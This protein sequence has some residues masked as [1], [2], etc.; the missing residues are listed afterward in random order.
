M[1]STSTNK[2]D[3][4]HISLDQHLL[5]SFVHGWTGCWKWLG[6]LESRVLRE[7]I[8]AVPIDRPVYVAGLARS[9]STI[10]LEFLAA[11][12]HVA[13]HRYSDFPLIFTPWWSHELQRKSPVKNAAPIERAHGDGIAITPQSPEAMEEPLWM[14]FFQDAHNPSCNQVMDETCASAAFESFYADHLRKLL[15]IRGGRRYVSKGNY[16][17]TRLAYLQKMFPD[18]RV[19]I[20]VRHPVHHIASL[21]KQQ[22]LFVKGE[23]NH[24]RALAHMQ[25][26]GHFAR[27]LDRRPINAG[28]G[29][30]IE[31]LP[32]LWAG[33]EEVRGWAAYWSHLYQFVMD[34]LQR[35]PGLRQATSIVR[36]EDLCDDPHKALSGLLEH[37]QLDDEGLVDAFAPTISAPTYYRP[38]F[39]DEEL[40]IIA[41]ETQEAASRFGYKDPVHLKSTDA[42]SSSFAPAVTAPAR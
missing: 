14:A 8:E 23:T 4:F 38:D 18:L 32:E 25:R 9:G 28:G 30:A 40:A 11:H 24:P 29:T 22:R 37:V 12:P 3:P 35:R 1:S 20:P 5:E 17:V 21:M 27:G 26:A 31:R 16:N 34:D 19:V 41:E 2:P 7:R 6:N 36:F 42:E 10:L 13:T 33:G 39:S 15:L